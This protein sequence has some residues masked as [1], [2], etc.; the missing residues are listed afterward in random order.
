[1]FKISCHQATNDSDTNNMSS[2]ISGGDVK[3]HS[4]RGG[5]FGNFLH[6]YAHFYQI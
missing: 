2:L 3:W 5:Q 6:N 1:M 4:H